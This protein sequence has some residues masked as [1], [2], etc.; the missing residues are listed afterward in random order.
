MQQA[1]TLGPSLAC[2][3]CPAPRRLPAGVQLPHQR[4]GLTPAQYSHWLDSH[5]P[6]GEVTASHS[7]DC[8]HLTHTQLRLLAPQPC[9]HPPVG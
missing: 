6:T 5:T 7:C 2:R 4:S 8:T 9:T 1:R 3:R